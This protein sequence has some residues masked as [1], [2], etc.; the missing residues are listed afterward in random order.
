MRVGLNRLSHTAAE[1]RPTA[2]CDPSWQ[3]KLT[4]LP[5]ATISKLAVQEAGPQCCGPET[6]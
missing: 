3:R 1:A 2:P 4:V 5:S 6:T